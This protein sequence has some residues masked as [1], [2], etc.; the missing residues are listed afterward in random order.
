MPAFAQNLADP[1]RRVPESELKLDLPK[2][3][4]TEEAR[5]FAAKP[6]PPRAVDPGVC[7]SARVNWQLA[8]GAPYSYKS[9]SLSCTE[10]HA[11]YRD[12]CG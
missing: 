8:C 10:A 12:S 9:R 1:G 4:A 5:S 2:R 11:I 3:D 7:E 6:P